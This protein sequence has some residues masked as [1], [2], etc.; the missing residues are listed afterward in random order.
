MGSDIG[1][2]L[3]AKRARL[4]PEQCGLPRGGQRRVPGLRREEVALLA[5]VSPDYYVRLEQGRAVSASEQVLDAVARVLRLDEVETEH[6]RHLVRPGR[7]NDA[8]RSDPVRVGLL[9][10]LDAMVDVPAFVLGPRMDI[11]TTNRLGDSVLPPADGAARRN[12]AAHVFLDPGAPAYYPEWAEVARD[13]A[14]HLRRTAGLR[15]DDRL[16]RELIGELAVGSEDF[17][18][19]WSRQDVAV[20]AH[21]TKVVQHPDAGL[22]EFAFETLTLASEPDHMLVTYTPTTEPTRDSL[23]ALGSLHAGDPA[24]VDLIQSAPDTTLR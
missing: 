5:G 24:R 22:L 4:S 21:G 12:A 2:F 23:A 7:R 13:T 15:P 9:A 3:S 20:K 10:L 1:D 14:A 16:L 19:I 6:L 17:V 8:A 11:V 18:R